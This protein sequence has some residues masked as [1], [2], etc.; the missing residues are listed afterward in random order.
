[1]S[2]PALLAEL[3]KYQPW[4]DREAAMTAGLRR[5]V[6]EN[7]RCFSRELVTGHITGSAWILDHTG[8]A[9]L[10]VHHG[11]LDR[12]LQPGGHCDDK[13]TALDA[14][15]REA[16]EET[17]VCG[18]EL[19]QQGIF[20][21]DVHGIPARKSEPSHVHYDVRYAFQA[22]P[23]CRLVISPESREVRWVKLADVPNLNP[24][25]SV[26]RMVQ[27]TLRFESLTIAG[28]ST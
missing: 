28:S 27:K 24:E 20:D 15:V 13:E 3:H 5:F 6:E 26:T 16:F 10:L 1:M 17:G 8:T 12:W 25:D 18:L 4:D 22:R 21:I 2:R 23:D 11:K 14:A 7:E 9:V 19:L